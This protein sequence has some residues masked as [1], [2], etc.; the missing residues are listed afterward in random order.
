MAYME[1]TDGTILVGV[2]NKDYLTPILSLEASFSMDGT[3][4]SAA[5]VRFRFLVYD[6]FGDRKFLGSVSVRRL[7][8]ED[9]L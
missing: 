9:P 8:T 6:V 3:A 5:S 4:Q 1:G 7:S 2:E